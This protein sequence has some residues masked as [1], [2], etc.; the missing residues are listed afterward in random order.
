MRERETVLVLCCKLFIF[1]NTVLDYLNGVN[2]VSWTDTSY[3]TKNVH[4]R[5]ISC[6]NIEAAR[7]LDP[8][9]TFFIDKCVGLCGS[10]VEIDEYIVS[11]Y[12]LWKD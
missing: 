1:R 6:G 4:F 2:P 9:K 8:A 12:A 7:G 11:R 5:Y 10:S 3:L